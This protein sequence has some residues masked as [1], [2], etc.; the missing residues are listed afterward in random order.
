VRARNLTGA[1]GFLPTVMWLST[2]FLHLD[3]G[4]VKPFLVSPIP[5]M[6]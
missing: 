4:F 1:K 2:W 5:G 6:Q 3:T